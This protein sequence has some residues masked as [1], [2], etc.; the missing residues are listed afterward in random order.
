MNVSTVRFRS[1]PHNRR[2]IDELTR[3]SFLYVSTGTRS[4]EGQV[5]TSL[6][7]NKAVTP[8]QDFGELLA[9]KF[10]VLT[11]AKTEA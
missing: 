7:E 8:R 1:T 11:T 3:Q 9:S 2:K 5:A 4:K 6:H 10:S